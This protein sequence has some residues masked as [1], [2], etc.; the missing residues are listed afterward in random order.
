VMAV[1]LGWACVTSHHTQAAEM[2]FS[3]AGF[4]V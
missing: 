3:K 4:S 1:L 2:F